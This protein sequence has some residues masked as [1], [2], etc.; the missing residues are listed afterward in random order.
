M[1]ASCTHA[2]FGNKVYEILDKDIK[3]RIKPYKKYY[4]M[5]LYGPD[6]VFFYKAY[7]RNE[8]NDHG[9]N[10]HKQSAHI[11]FE[12]A[13]TIIQQ[14][15]NKD[16]CIA[17]IC[18]FMNHFILDS[19]VHG[20][21]NEAEKLYNVSHARIEADLDRALLA[22]EGFVPSK[23]SYTHFI[24]TD[25]DIAKVMAPFF[26]LDEDIM[27]TT[28]KHMKLFNN[29]F[30]CPNKFKGWIVKNAL[31]S[32]GIKSIYDMII[33]NEEDERCKIC[34]PKL[35]SMLD[36]SI[37]I[38]SKHIKLFYDILETSQNVDER[39]HKDFN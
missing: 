19:E 35:V 10:I 6:P 33:I 1:P 13:R 39:L 32:L 11:F 4:I 28:I 2:Y 36:E 18:G 22:R 31:T 34:T 16:A 7:K 3:N 21:V 29:A 26:E 8:I 14:S 27:H 37:P 24:Y 30:H 25:K 23:T 12:K 15:D 17:Y 20:Y 5:G 38:A 9:D